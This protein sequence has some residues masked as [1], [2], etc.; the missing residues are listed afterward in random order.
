[1]YKKNGFQLVLLLTLGLVALSCSAADEQSKTNQLQTPKDL[2]E[3]IGEDHPCY[4]FVGLASED[5]MRALGESSGDPLVLPESMRDMDSP[6]VY[7]YIVDSEYRKGSSLK[8]IRQAVLEKC[9]AN[10]K[11]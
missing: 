2:A 7:A 10:K 11:L 5:S 1:M 9:I 3:D 4:K 6:M 8:E